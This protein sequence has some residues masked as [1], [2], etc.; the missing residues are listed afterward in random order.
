MFYKFVKNTLKQIKKI[1]ENYYKNIFIMNNCST[2][3]KTIEYL[4]EVDV[5][6]IQM[7]ANIAP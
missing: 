5:K 7:P 3:P 4:N 2:C 6:I 1:N